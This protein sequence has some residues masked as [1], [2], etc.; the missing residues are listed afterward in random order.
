MIEVKSL[1]NIFSNFVEKIESLQHEIVKLKSD[2]KNLLTEIE[3]MQREK[4][5]VNTKVEFKKRKR[6]PK[7]R[8]K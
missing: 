6:K 7:L 3:S 5:M 4:Y 8:K 2:N 1:D